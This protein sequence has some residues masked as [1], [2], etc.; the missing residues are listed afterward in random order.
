MLRAYTNVAERKVF[1]RT[2]EQ[3]NEGETFLGTID[4]GDPGP[5]SAVGYKGNQVLFHHV[6]EL[7]IKAKLF[8]YPGYQIIVEEEEAP[9]E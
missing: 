2:A 9:A 4:L 8:G 7:A 1:V 5:N 6:E 3:T